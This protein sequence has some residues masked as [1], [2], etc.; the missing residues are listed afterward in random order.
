MTGSSPVGSTKVSVWQLLLNQERPTIQR[1]GDRFE[2][3][4][5]YQTDP[6][7]ALNT[8]SQRSQSLVEHLTPERTN[9]ILQTSKWIDPTFH[10]ERRKIKYLILESTMLARSI[11][12]D[13]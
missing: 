7:H 11:I 3:G 13:L 6:V 4:R 2:L 9:V 10:V 1:E 12:I 5:A 8:S